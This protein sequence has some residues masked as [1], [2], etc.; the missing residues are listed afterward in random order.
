MRGWI[1]SIAPL[2]LVGGCA[3][4]Y[5]PP[6]LTERQTAEL[7]KAL[8]GKVA[9]EPQT[10]LNR[11]PQTNLTVISNNIVLYRV[12]RNLV[13]KNELIGSCSG[14]ASGDTL[15]VRSFSSQLCRGDFATTA[16]LQSGV[17]TGACALGDF[18]PYR[19]P[20]R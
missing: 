1:M 5:S 16:N 20:G 13:Y 12:N 10:C 15:I 7:E 18:V 11:R 14:L 4:G 19:T 6:K 9:G 8:A 3:G 17:Q 2:L